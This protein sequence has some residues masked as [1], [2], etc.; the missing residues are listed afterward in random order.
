M[1][2]FMKQLISKNSLI[3][4]L[5]FLSGCA[6]NTTVAPSQNKALNSVTNSNA[7][8]EKS[9]WMQSHLD[10]FFEKKWNPAM[11][12]DKNIQKKYGKKEGKSFTLQEFVDK[13]A[14]YKKVDLTDASKSNVKKL[15]SMPIIG[16]RYYQK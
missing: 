14:A 16:K 15:E 4:S 10:N 8:K 7:K 9:Y 1:M 6:T 13:Q 5:V 3:L 12:R 11:K 2:L